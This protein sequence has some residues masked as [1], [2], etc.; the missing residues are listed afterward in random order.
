MEVLQIS[1]INFSLHLY[2]E[3]EKRSNILEPTSVESSVQVYSLSTV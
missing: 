3:P 2:D 1:N